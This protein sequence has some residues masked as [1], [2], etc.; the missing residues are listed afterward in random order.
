MQ[1]RITQSFLAALSLIGVLTLPSA[2]SA[3]DD[4]GY[5]DN[6]KEVHREYRQ[7]SYADREDLH[8]Y[9]RSSDAYRDYYSR[10]RWYG[11]QRRYGNRY[12]RGD[13]CKWTRRSYE[14]GRQYHPR[15]YG[16]D[17]YGYVR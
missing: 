3:H 14:M 9:G 17:Y 5:Y 10:D 7:P 12:S 13:G 6:R 15:Y 11:G 1:A 8:L 16:S 4:E 2:A